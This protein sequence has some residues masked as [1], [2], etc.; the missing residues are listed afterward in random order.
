M[1]ITNCFNYKYRFNNVFSRNNLHKIKNGASF[2]NLNDKNSL[3]THWVSLFIHR[4]VAI[5]FG[6]FGIEYISQEVL[7]RM[8]EIIQLLKIECKI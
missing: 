6:S 4:N 5:Y 3:G 2:I 8:R 1:N 7:N